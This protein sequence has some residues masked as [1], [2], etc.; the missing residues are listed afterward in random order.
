[1][2]LPCVDCISLAICKIR[3]EKGAHTRS[4]GGYDELRKHC[5]LIREY[6]SDLINPESN[7]TV[8]KNKEIHELIDYM[9]GLNG[10]TTVC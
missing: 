6:V 7:V 10:E 4:F 5:I 8:I 1:M 2:K 9:K 3:F